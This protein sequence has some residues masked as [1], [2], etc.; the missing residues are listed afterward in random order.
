MHIYKRDIHAKLRTF[1]FLYIYTHECIHTYIIYMIVGKRTQR[2][3]LRNII[4]ANIHSKDRGKHS[5]GN[6]I[7]ASSYSET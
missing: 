6:I 1:V 3:S 2:S 5:L 4:E 7:E